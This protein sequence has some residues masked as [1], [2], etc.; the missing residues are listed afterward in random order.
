MTADPKIHNHELD[1][2]LFFDVGPEHHHC[3]MPADQHDY[4]F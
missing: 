2:S 4:F 1:L 3:L